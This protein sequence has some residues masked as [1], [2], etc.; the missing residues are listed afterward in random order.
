MGGRRELPADARGRRLLAGAV[1][2]PLVRARHDSD[3]DRAGDRDGAV[4]E[5][6]DRGPRLPAARLFHADR[7]ADDRGGQHLALLLHAA[8]RTAEPGR[9][10]ARL[11]QP[12]LARR[13]RH[14]ARRDH[15]RIGLE[16]GRLL[17]DLLPGGAA[18]GL[19][20][21]RR[22]GR[23][24]GRLARAVFLAR[25][26]SAAD[27]DHAVRADHRADQL[28]AHDR[29]AVRDD[30]RRPRPRKHPA[31]PLHLRGRLQLLGFGLRAGATGR[32]ARQPRRNRAREVPLARPAHPLPMNRDIATAAP[33]LEREADPAHAT[34]AFLGARLTHALET[35]GAWLLG[36]LW[37]LPLAYAVWTAFHPTEYSTRFELDAPLT[38][39]NF[40]AAWHAARFARY[41]WN[42]FLL[43]TMVLAAQLVLGTLAAYA[44]ARFEFR[45]RDV[46]FFLVLLQL[47][48]SE[49]HTSE[50]QSRENLV[51]RLLLEKK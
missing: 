11:R 4:G 38:L 39:E 10:G 44:F 21:A 14:R 20:D 40:I 6:E 34:G 32:R 24:R 45:G 7:A 3:V 36:L 5:R 15:G 42:T 50:L 31:A 48:R 43:V 49:E 30:A 8:I 27:A 33:A 25:A 28:G 37:I 29:P 35:A 23:A 9:A 18:A 2:Q 1:E 51:C 22:S 19:A 26:V 46:L 13:P 12:Q 41:F 47:M 16:G 17:H